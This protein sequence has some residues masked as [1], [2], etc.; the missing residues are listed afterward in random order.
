MW[1][2][3]YQA[4]NLLAAAG[5]AVPPG[6]V[7]DTADAAVTAARQLGG[8]A[9]VVKAQVHAGARGQAGGVLRVASPE[10]AGQVCAQLLG[11][12]LVTPQTSAGGLPVGRVLVERAL[13]V[14]QELYV[15][16]TLDRSARRL[17]LMVSATG[18]MQ[19][20]SQHGDLR[21]VTL[22]PDSGVSPWAC[23]EIAYSLELPVATRAR[24]ADLLWRLQD[25]ARERDLILIEVN[26]LGV[27]ED[28]SLVALD[29]KMQLD[30]N[31]LLRQPLFQEL[32]DPAQE[33][34]RETRAREYGLSF[35]A[36]DGDIGCMVNGAGL[37][38]A[39][40]DLIRLHGGAPANF[41]DVGGGTT[42]ARVAQAFGLIT[43]SRSVRTILV[44]IFGGIVRCDLIAEGVLQ[45][46]QQT[47]VS[48]PV[49]V[50]LEGTHAEQGRALLAQS[51]LRL[52]SVAG[53]DE[54]AARAVLRARG[55]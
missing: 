52:D 43:E 14:R 31:A 3:E 54:A 48:V 22:D 40:L 49:V 15:A 30:E 39:T 36:L 28:E 35:V 55:G 17:R 38:M 42:A 13:A 51:G 26:P 4:K 29:A 32:R 8:A 50:R 7:V 23:R 1:I 2:H 9:W 20:E 47:A 12:R 6:V 45:A 18:G 16:C 24:L 46:I 44:N 19:V 5:I 34:A 10:E 37:A 53:L 25:L 33:D 11:R 27:L 41:L 21:D